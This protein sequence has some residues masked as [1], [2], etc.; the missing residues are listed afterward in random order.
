MIVKLDLDDSRV[1][2]TNVS[3][4]TEE[5]NY[6]MFHIAPTEGKEMKKCIPHTR[7]KFMQIED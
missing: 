4:V 5:P 1:V 2:Y 3:Q 6:M 7:I